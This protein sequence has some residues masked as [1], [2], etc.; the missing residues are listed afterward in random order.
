MPFSLLG[1]HLIE[2]E[3][4]KTHVRSSKIEQPFLD[5]NN[6]IDVRS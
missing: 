3:A 6:G 4:L 1:E 2:N 5:H